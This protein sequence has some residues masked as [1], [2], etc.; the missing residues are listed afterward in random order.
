MTQLRA[1]LRSRPALAVVMV[2][3]GSWTVTGCSVIGVDRSGG[4][5]STSSVSAV[6][7][8]SKDLGLDGAGVPAPAWSARVGRVAAA[9]GPIAFTLSGRGCVVAVNASTGKA[10][11]AQVAAGQS[12]VPGAAAGSGTL[13]VAGGTTLPGPAS[14]YVVDRLTALD[15]ATGKQRWT[16]T[17][18]GDGQQVPAVVAGSTVVVSQDDGSVTGLS[19]ATGAVTWSVPRP[20]GC[21]SPFGGEGTQPVLPLASVLDG[22]GVVVTVALHCHGHD[23]VAAIVPSTGHVAWTWQAP[24]GWTVDAGT[25]AGHADGVVGF[26]AIGSPGYAT[27]HRSTWT[28]GPADV[29]THQLVALD[30]AT[31]AALWEQDVVPAAAGVYAGPAQLCLASVDG[32][33]CHQARTGAAI[34]QWFPTL[35]SGLPHPTGGIVALDGR[36]Y[37]VAPTDAVKAIDPS[38]TTQ[39][40][41][42]GAFHLRITDIATGHVTADQPLPSYHYDPDR[43][44][45]SVDMPPGVLA[46]TDGSV[47]V[48]PQ[49]RESDVVLTIRP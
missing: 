48:S 11:W 1:A 32:V 20:P 40:A 7:G 38:S 25:P 23:Q 17:L 2:L 34:W 12:W 43:V 14:P 5:C 21:A 19:T 44:V 6:R 4:G 42:P 18:P 22:G 41:P 30:Q 33:Q 46:V 37:Q 39:Q 24:P 35:S 13:V 27:P 9:D 47:F 36:L 15:E 16:V 10:V 28:H 8:A 31:G 29:Q 3:A 26:M 49:N 45:P